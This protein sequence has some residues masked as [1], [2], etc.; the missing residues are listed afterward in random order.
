VAKSTIARRQHQIMLFSATW[1][2]VL[3]G[4]FFYWFTANE[5][6]TTLAQAVYFACVTTTTIGY[7]DMSP[8]TTV[9]RVVLVL[10]C[11]VGI[12]LMG[13]MLKQLGEL[14]LTASEAPAYW[15]LRVVVMRVNPSYFP[16]FSTQIWREHGINTDLIA[17][18]ITGNTKRKLWVGNIPSSL[19]SKQ[20]LEE[21]FGKVGTVETVTLPD[22]EKMTD[23]ESRWAL[24]TMAKP[25]G[26]KH[27]GKQKKGKQ[28]TDVDFVSIVAERPNDPVIGHDGVLLVL[29]AQP[30]LVCRHMLDSGAVSLSRLQVGMAVCLW[31]TFLLGVG[32]F[33][34]MQTHSWTWE[35]SVYFTFITMSTIGYGDYYPNDSGAKY[36]GSAD[37]QHHQVFVWCMGV[38]LIIFALSSFSFVYATVQDNILEQRDLQEQTALARERADVLTAVEAAHENGEGA[39]SDRRETE[40]ARP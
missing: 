38:V 7:G 1:L 32:P 22:V 2:Y 12:G 6:F 29:P 40:P 26:S 11:C 39:H 34:A 23:P 8:S 15:L 33:Y 30:I 5:E 9:G 3:A 17:D 27:A 24:V 28:K 18:N 21:T 19:A 35:Q 37:A 16:G 31:M 20:T 25:G 13:A 10:Y 4:A 14:L 36:S